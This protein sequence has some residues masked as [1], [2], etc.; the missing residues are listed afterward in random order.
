MRQT[1]LDDF[2]CDVLY[3]THND[4]K[5]RFK[6][7]NELADIKAVINKYNIQDDDV[8]IKLTGRYKLQDLSFIQ[9]VKDNSSTYDAF[10]KFF[11]VCS[12]KF[13]HNDCV[14]GLFAIKCKHLKNFNYSF[15][16]GSEIEFTEHVRNT[17]E[18]NKIMEINQLNLECCFADNLRMLIV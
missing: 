7:G 4:L 9:L 3:T 10:I 1:F 2:N 6:S 5:F 11:N 17:I 16:R 18:T 13:M 14:L 12:R 8:I 15:R